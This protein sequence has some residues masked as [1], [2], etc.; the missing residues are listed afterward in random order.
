MLCLGFQA[1]RTHDYLGVILAGGQSRRMGQDK[2]LM[3][4]GGAT[5]FD[6]VLHRFSCQ[7]D[8]IIISTASH[9]SVFRHCGRKIVRD[10]AP[11]QQIGPLSG[12]Y[13]AFD[14][15]QKSNPDHPYQGIITIAVDT[16]F[17]P[18]DYVA[19]LRA[20][21]NPKN[22]KALIATSQQKQHPTFAF[23]PL[24]L[25]SSLWRHL[26]TGKRSIMS[27]ANIITAENIAFP[28]TAEGKDPFFNINNRQE[29][30]L[31]CDYLA[32][33]RETHGKR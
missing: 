25:V 33:L 4:F 7:I 9:H 20:S 32:V 11:F 28:F 16:P 10:I 2:A 24:N 8:D 31:A 21:I 1:M 30:E 29:W 12:L 14:Y 17:F 3:P 13:A 26:A 27:F 5:L 23:W 18:D 22:P 6:Y 15:C 19:C